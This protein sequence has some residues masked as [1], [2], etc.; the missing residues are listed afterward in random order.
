MMYVTGL[1][2]NCTWSKKKKTSLLIFLS[3][4]LSYLRLDLYS[5]KQEVGLEK[6]ASAVEGAEMKRFSLAGAKSDR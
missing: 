3:K 1:T 4:C 5:G 2:P 6:E